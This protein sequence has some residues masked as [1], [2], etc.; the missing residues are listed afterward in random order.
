[1]KPGDLVRAKPEYC[2][3]DAPLV[4]MIV[5]VADHPLFPRNEFHRCL[6]LFPSGVFPMYTYEIEVI[7]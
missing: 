3:P 7:E 5:E 2:E 6:V 1:M 4:G